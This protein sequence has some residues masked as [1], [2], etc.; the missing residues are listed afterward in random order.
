[1]KGFINKALKVAASYNA[2]DWGWLKVTLIAFGILVGTYFAQFF[3]QY[4]V[5]VWIIF[6][7]SYIWIVYKT[8]FK[9]WGKT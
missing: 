9:Y 6:V 5:I 7:L 1:M 8:F 3:M 2:W 4:I